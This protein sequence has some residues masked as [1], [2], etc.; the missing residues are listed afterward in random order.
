MDWG[1]DFQVPIMLA[2]MIT[3]VVRIKSQPKFSRPVKNYTPIELAKMG[4]SEAKKLATKGKKATG[5]P[6]TTRR[7]K[8]QKAD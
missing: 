2:F 4:A 5:S 7:S 3:L 6:K 8:S 1:K